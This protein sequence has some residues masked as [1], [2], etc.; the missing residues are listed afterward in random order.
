MVPLGGFKTKEDMKNFGT[1]MS[2]EMYLEE[3]KRVK[4]FINNGT[5]SI[6]VHSIKRA[7]ENNVHVT[8]ISGDE[9]FY[10]NKGWT[11]FQILDYESF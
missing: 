11:K 8:F 2:G 5:L 3:M 1:A 7:V 10:I 6:I 4:R 9:G